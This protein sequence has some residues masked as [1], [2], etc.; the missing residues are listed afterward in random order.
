MSGEKKG[1][2]LVTLLKLAVALLVLLAVVVL[3]GAAMM[4]SEFSYAQTT[5]IKA[6]RDDV[7]E[8][9]GD[10]R[11]WNDWG[12]WKDEDPDMKI[13][14]SEKTNEAGGWQSW[15]GDK[16]GEGK[17]EFTKVSEKEGVEY[18]I[19]FNGKDT[20]VGGIKYEDAEGGTKVTWWWKGPAGYPIERW[21][22]KVGGSMI[23]DMFNEGLSNL[24]SKVEAEN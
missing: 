21:F 3:G 2:I 10:M 6:D 12:P 18:R 1:N 9:V 24:K 19:W 23:D 22:H 17:M 15:T 7:H 11:R 5:T 13:T 16:A 20:G 14:Y 8:W 4:P